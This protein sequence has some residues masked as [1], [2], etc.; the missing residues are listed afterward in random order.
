[1]RRPGG[2]TADGF[3]LIPEKYKAAYVAAQRAIVAKK[4]R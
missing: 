2:V 1:M 4:G 3:W